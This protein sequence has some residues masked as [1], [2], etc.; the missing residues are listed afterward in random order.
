M[1]I[2]KKLKNPVISG[3]L[4]LSIAGILGKI[5]GFF[6]RIFLSRTIGAEGLGIYQL[7]FPISTICFA[8]TVSGL[9]AALSKFI[10]EYQERDPASPKRFLRICLLI[11]GM[12]SVGIMALLIRQSGF[13]AENILLEPRCKPLV[14]ILAY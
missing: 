9:S 5:I 11:S 2:P 10:A 7:I 8:I 3:A 12:L 6:Y 13:I 1:Q 14:P 4:L